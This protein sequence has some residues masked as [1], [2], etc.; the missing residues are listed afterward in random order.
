MMLWVVYASTAV[1]MSQPVGH[2]SITTSSQQK[3]CF[4]LEG[5]S[6]A[7]TVAAVV[8]L[9]D[10]AQFREYH[11]PTHKSNRQ[12]TTRNADMSSFCVC[13]FATSAADRPKSLSS[14]TVHAV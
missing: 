2:R 5:S 13:Q 4:S 11:P 7:A 12:E 10:F 1:G 3:A 6:L 8:N 9:D 14:V